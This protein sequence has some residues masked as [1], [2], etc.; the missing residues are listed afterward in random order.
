[1]FETM[2]GL[3]NWKKVVEMLTRWSR[4]NFF[5]GKTH[6]I[7]CFHFIFTSTKKPTYNPSNLLCKSLFSYLWTRCNENLH[8]TPPQNIENIK[9][10]FV[11]KKK[12]ESDLGGGP[13]EAPS[14]IICYI[15]NKTIANKNQLYSYLINPRSS[16]E[17]NKVPSQSLYDYA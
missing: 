17:N 11:N 8:I 12:K 16:G 14:I 13:E 2:I 1:M 5:Q 9:I 4:K 10:L 15:R 3:Q 7:F 6:F